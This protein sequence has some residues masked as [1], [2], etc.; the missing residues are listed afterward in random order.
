MR[1]FISS[2]PAQRFTDNRLGFNHELTISFDVLV[3]TWTRIKCYCELL[4]RMVVRDTS[5]FS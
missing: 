1:G 2:A 5:F 4:M 3:N